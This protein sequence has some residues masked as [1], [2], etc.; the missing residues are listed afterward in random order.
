MDIESDVI[1]PSYTDTEIIMDNMSISTT[2]FISRF[3]K[4]KVDEVSIDEAED[5]I[6]FNAKYIFD[7]SKV[8]SLI[9]LKYTDDENTVSWEKRKEKYVSDTKIP[10]TFQELLTGNFGDRCSFLFAL[11]PEN[12]NK[13]IV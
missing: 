13:E 11:H 8:V 3:E 9:G 6:C 12:T 2:E 1:L 4:F 7:E 5:D 10:N